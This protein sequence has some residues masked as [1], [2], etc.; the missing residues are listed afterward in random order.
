MATAVDAVG[1]EEE[2][3]GRARVLEAVDHKPEGF[4]WLT[5]KMLKASLPT[6][7]TPLPLSLPQNTKHVV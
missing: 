7:P 4:R 1:G 5:L 2:E 3:K 6:S